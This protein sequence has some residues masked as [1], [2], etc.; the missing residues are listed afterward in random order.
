[1]FRLP[2]QPVAAVKWLV[3]LIPMAGVIGSAS[4]FFLWSL[5][6]LTRVRFANSWLLWLLPVGGAAVGWIYHHHGKSVRR[7]KQPAH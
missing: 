2:F 3:V 5:D 1:M 4:A 7:R 6:A